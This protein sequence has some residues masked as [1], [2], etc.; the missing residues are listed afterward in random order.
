MSTWK[1]TAACVGA[2]RRGT[3]Q[4]IDPRGGRLAFKTS[5]SVQWIAGE[6]LQI[7]LDKSAFVP[8]LP[9]TSFRANNLPEGLTINQETGKIEG[10]IMSAVRCTMSVEAYNDSGTLQTTIDLNVR[11]QIAPQGL[12]FAVPV[13][14][15]FAN[16]PHTTGLLLEGTA[17]TMRP[18]YDHEGLPAGTFSIRPS[19]PAGIALD[20]QTGVIQ[21]TPYRVTTRQDYMVT[22]ENSAGKSDCTISLEVQKHK[23]PSVKYSFEHHLFVGQSLTAIEPIVE[24]PGNQ[25]LFSVSPPLPTGLMM[26]TA[27]GKISGAAA[28]VKATTVFTVTARNLRGEQTSTLSLEIHG[29]PT[30]GLA[31]EMPGPDEFANPPGLLLV[32][33]AMT[34]KPKPGMPRGTFRVVPALPAGLSIDAQDGHITGIP[35]RA[36]ARRDYTVTLENPAG[37]TDCTISLE[38]QEHKPPAVLRYEPALRADA[39]LSKIFLV[40][41]T[42]KLEPINV[43]LANHLVF[44]VSPGLPPGLTLDPK[45]AI[46]EG[47]LPVAMEKTTFIVTARNKRGQQSSEVVF[48]VADDWHAA[49]HRPQKWTRCMVQMWMTSKEA[50]ELPDEDVLP[51]IDIDGEQLVCLDTPQAMD[52]QFP[53]LP[54]MHKQFISSQIYQLVQNAEKA[55]LVGP[56]Y[57]EIYD[58]LKKTLSEAPRS[59]ASKMRGKLND[60]RSGE[61]EDAALG[62]R[63]FLKVP[64]DWD[65]AKECT[66]EGMEGEVRRLIDCPECA[67][68]HAE[69][70]R[71]LKRDVESKITERLSQALSKLLEARRSTGEAKASVGTISFLEEEVKEIRQEIEVIDGWFYGRKNAKAVNWPHDSVKHQYGT[72]GQPLCECCKKYS[73]DYSTISADL[74]YVLHEE[75]SEKECFNGVR[76]KGRN[77]LG[78][79]GG[80]MRLDDF[81]QLKEAVETKLSRA[82]VAALRFY[83]SHSFTAINQPLRDTGRQTQH[84]LS[85]ITFNIQEGIKKL[86][87]LDAKGEKATAE[88]N[89]WRGFADMQV[90]TEFKSKGGS[91]YAP[92]STSTKAGIATGYAVRRGVMDGALLMKLKTKNNLQRGAELTWLS[93]FPG[94][95]ETLYPPLTFLQ[96]TGAEQVIEYDG[97]KLSVVEVE[98]T[99]P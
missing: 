57:E 50:L 37:K 81:M 80:G 61:F 11:G 72:Y 69:I 56:A 98:P 35:E 51:F 67:K 77:H 91:E 34:L 25:L 27:T 13:A 73:L 9:S 20:Q 2:A 95:A 76:D 62:L 40:N 55:N 22:L 39:R 92:M 3:K 30:G 12:R 24:D 18:T 52:A 45:T 53:N 86:R 93:M 85:A 78:A 90:S 4:C 17:V 60:L 84:P 29:A 6:S 23:E 41:H 82:M 99:V 44:S 1:P 15:E 70:L 19:L 88:V 36:T 68:I 28:D 87:G 31:Y 16:P 97:I 63:P 46:I 14:S 79:D 43:D 59:G 64:A 75:S 83:T 54:K 10:T 33:D 74:N 48:G 8:G 65:E 21:G 96:P 7:E 94:E 26:D 42:I 58:A 49:L 71:E 38:V 89:L 5:V 47:T 66:I 32:D